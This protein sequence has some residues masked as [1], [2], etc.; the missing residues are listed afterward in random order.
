MKKK[1]GRIIAVAGG[2]GGVGKSVVA[3]NLAITIGRLGYKTTIVDADLGAPTLHTMLGVTRPGPGLGGFLDHEAATLGEV[4]LE[5][6]G[7]SNLRLV[8]G[9]ARNGAANINA[10]QKLRLLR[11]IAHLGGDVVVVDVGAGSSFNTIDLVAAADLKLLVM[12]PQLPSLQNAYAFLKGCVQRSLRR[13]PDDAEAR[14]RLDE[15]MGGD[16]DTRPVQQAVGELVQTDPELALSIV[17]VLGRFGVVLVGNMLVGERDRAVLSRM[18]KMISDY[19]MMQAPL[20]ATLRTAE[21]VRK[22]IDSRTPIAIADSAPELSAELRKLARHC[23]DADVKRLRTAGRD[24]AA[25][26]TLPIWIERDAPP[27]R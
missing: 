13:L 24:A 14:R 8:P 7:A 21:P 4:A 3:L 26:K 17:D 9:S 12:T 19:L 16:G 11:A 10:G 6:S 1:A 15:L 27:P 25:D 22:S 5:V 23:L 20:V 18:S 2:K